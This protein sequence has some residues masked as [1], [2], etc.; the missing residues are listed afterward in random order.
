M[1][2]LLVAPA[3]AAQQLTPRIGLGLALTVTF[4]LAVTW[5]GL[6]LSYFTN[7]SV[8]FFVTSLAFGIYVL[9]RRGSATRRLRR[10]NRR[11]VVEVPG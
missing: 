9:S 4:A 8:G 11:V 2:A 6:G 1:F 3:A 10:T 5:I 7:Y